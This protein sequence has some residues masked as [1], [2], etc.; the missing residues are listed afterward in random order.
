MALN[1]TWAFYS[2]VATDQRA[3][4]TLARITGL[5]LQRRESVQ[6]LVS[7]LKGSFIIK[8]METRWK[9]WASCF[10]SG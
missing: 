7:L 9:V 5:S 8:L 1:Y 6:T 4:L 10:L 3:R 2:A